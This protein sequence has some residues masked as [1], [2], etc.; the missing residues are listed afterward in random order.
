MRLTG[1]GHL[2]D[3]RV[4][5]AASGAVLSACVLFWALT[6]DLTTLVPRH[7][8]VYACAFAAYLVALSAAPRLS[9]RAVQGA[10][11]AAFLWRAVLLPAA[12]LLSD[13]I[14]RYIWEGRIQN[15]GGNPY[16]W[17]DR[18][19][20]PRWGSDLRDETWRRV[21]NRDY[22][23]IY[24]PLW[25]LAARGVVTLH[26]SVLAMK[27]FVVA[28]EI[29]TLLVLLRILGRRGL[30]RGRILV[31]AWSPLALVEI[32]GSGHNDPLGLL[33]LALGLLAL[34]SGRPLAA[35]LATGLGF[36]AKLLPGFIGLSWIRRFR[37]THV[38]AGA[39]VAAIVTWPYL[40]AGSGLL[41]SLQKYGALIRFNESL[42]ALVAFVVGEHVPALRVSALLLFATAL[43]LAWRRT[44]PA[45]SALVVPAASLLL[46]ANVLPWYALWLLP[47]LVL[48]DCPP[49]LLFTGTV[50]LTYLVYPGWLAGGPW[51]VGWTVR[52]FEYGPVLVA[53]LW[54]V[55]HR[56]P[57]PPPAVPA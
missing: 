5:V 16:R 10:L 8:P 9:E 2:Q 13:D 22:T 57:A 32:A 11:A 18:V 24:P 23:A 50:A 42:F 51:H 21:N 35:A 17:S 27:A 20:A 41:A 6:G 26:D 44:E 39:A 29:G 48:R 3:P 54:M 4:V 1:F 43:V 45:T 33:L 34:D 55:V 7:L 14:Y 40:S 46:T 47:G 38:L 30:P 15:H 12:P 53:A 56:G 25:Q 37:W 19:D 28:A 36:Q 49:A 31:F 52:A